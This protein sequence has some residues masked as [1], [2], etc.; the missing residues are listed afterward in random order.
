MD[1]ENK[2]ISFKTSDTGNRNFLLPT[3]RRAKPGKPNEIPQPRRDPDTVP[4]QEPEPGT[5]PTK[6]PEIMPGEE[7]LTTPP[8]APP[9]IPEPPQSLMTSSMHMKMFA[10]K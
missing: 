6:L 5:W 4:A 10:V 2:T 1:M 3:S 7:P 9:E 8:A